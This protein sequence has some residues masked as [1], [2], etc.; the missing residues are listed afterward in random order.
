MLV[1]TELEVVQVLFLVV[2]FRLATYCMNKSICDHALDRGLI[3]VSIGH[4]LTH[5]H[6]SYYN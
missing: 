1:A 4:H 2:I 5:H 6:I 3:C